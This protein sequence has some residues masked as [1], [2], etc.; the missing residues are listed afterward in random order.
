MEENLEKLKALEIG[1]LIKNQKI[2]STKTT[3]YFLSRIKKINPDVNAII[4]IDE[5]K[6]I[7][8]AEL[9]DKK[10]TNGEKLSPLAG[11]PVIVKDNINVLDMPTTCGSKMLANHVSIYDAT[12]IEKLKQAGLII[13]GKANMDEFAMGSSNEHSYFGPAKN[14]HNH[15]RVP[16]GSSGGSA[17][18]IASGMAPLALG[19]D[20][21]GSVRQPA[22]F[23]GVV[24]M[25]PSYGRVSRYGLTAFASSFDQI[26]PLANNIEDAAQLL[27]IISGYDKRDS[28]SVEMTSDVSLKLTKTTPEK[29]TIGIDRSLMRDGIQP[30]IIS[31]MDNTIKMLLDNGAKVIAISLP[32]PEL[33]LAV[34]YIL[35]DCEASSN[36]ARYDAV[37]YGYRAESYNPIEEMYQNS[38]SEGFGI[39]VKRRIIL[40]TYALSAGYYDKY[41]RKA[42]KARRLIAN[43]I[44]AQ[45]QKCDLILTPTTP[46]TAFELGNKLENPL[47]M[48]LSDI[49]M[50]LA[51]LAGLPAIS[52]PAGIDSDGMPIGLHLMGRYGRDD[53]VLQGA[54]L[55]EGMLNA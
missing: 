21:A 36:L 34:Y 37:R 27:K 23:C 44:N 50:T 49:F 42:L 32:S 51:P 30:E 11:L 13:I 46:T 9:I 25:R 26:G 38:R 45:F 19:S 7:T 54:V 10:I 22:A 41:Y 48:Y 18:V 43:E 29:T 28:T 47:S 33:C 17:A 39:E 6:A 15:S 12:V 14:P 3:I 52:V 20:T 2:S 35:A 5:E 16:G 55:L 31:A 1:K 40:G 24:G 53:K 8:D 4:H